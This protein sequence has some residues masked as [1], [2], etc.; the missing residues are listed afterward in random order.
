MQF[1]REFWQTRKKL[2]LG[3]I[4]S[5][6]GILLA[7]LLF[8]A[9]YF[10]RLFVLKE[11]K[12]YGNVKVSKEDIL[13]MLDLKGGEILYRLD[14]VQLRER[15]KKHHL[16]E[17]VMLRRQL[18][19]ILVVQVKERV[20]LAILVQNNKGYLVDRNG[21]ILSEAKPNDI[22]YYPYVFIEDEKNKDVFFNF[23]AWL[24]QNKKYLPVY[25]NLQKILLT[26]D[27]IILYT[28]SHI[29]IYLPLT[30]ADELFRLYSYLDRI[31]T[32]IY[33]NHLEDRVE[34]IRLD[35]PFGRALVKYRSA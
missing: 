9:L 32:Y 10:T 12:V 16:I 18:P 21:V 24:K 8:Y 3:F 19:S 29:T 34:L 11:I 35:Y 7:G 13:R 17:D 26:K 23:L 31:M 5:L 6:L 2:F 1:V 15:L 33:D 20:P 14:L 4:F 28:K 25:E 27:K 30:T 22:L